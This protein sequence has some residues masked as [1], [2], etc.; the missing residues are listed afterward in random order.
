MNTSP[1]G[2]SGVLRGIVLMTAGCLLLTVNDSIMKWLTGD[3][4]PGEAIF[5]RGLF[6]AIPVALLAYRA[7]GLRALRVTNLPGQ[8][9][10]AVTLVASVFLF[11]TSLRY[12]PLA[13]AIALTFAGPL[14]L[15]AAAPWA[16]GERVGW[17]LRCAVV[18]GF[19][20]VLIMLA[21]GREGVRWAAFL[22]L[23]A[24]FFEAARDIVTRRLVA[25]ESSISLTAYSTALVTVCALATAG[26][27]WRPPSAGDAGLLALAGCC[28][29]AAL[30]LMTEAFRYAKATLVAPF[31]YSS[32]LW[33]MIIGV[34]VFGDWP[35]PA[36][37]AGGR[38]GGRERALHPALRGAALRARPGR[39]T[40]G[41]FT[42]PYD[43][44]S[45]LALRRPPWGRRPP[46]RRCSR[47]RCGM[48]VRVRCAARPRWRGP[49]A[50]PRLQ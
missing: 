4:P 40:L 26:H 19:A 42:T 32:V 20:G 16:L 1:P 39:F 3:Y 31:R 12:L 30:F 50:S 9:L 2:T 24:A 46:S 17:R 13:D 5:V 18:A 49:S 29:G 44:S 41:R 45:A 6:V 21:P 8:L 25:T 48:R 47:L 10:R 14:I 11:I 27:G 36:M 22:P 23:G 37:L 28:M 15:T 38:P 33:A 35:S 34:I 43:E 7:G